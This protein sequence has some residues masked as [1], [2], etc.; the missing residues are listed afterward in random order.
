ME[1]RIDIHTTEPLAFKA[2]MGLESYLANAD[3]SKTLKELIK[4]RASQLNHC[5]YCIAMHAKD[6][7]KNGE[8]T[9]RIL[10]LSA[11]REATKFFTEEEQVVLEMTEEITLIHQHGLKEETYRKA[12]EIFTESQIA[13]II[14]VIVTINAW[15]RIAVSTHKQIE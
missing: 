13:Q 10:L 3:I 6:A 8:N 2:M 15:N 5:A 4:I 12:S 14:M 7:I 1:N 11:W 9:Q